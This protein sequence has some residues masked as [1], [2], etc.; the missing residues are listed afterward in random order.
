MTAFHYSPELNAIAR[1]VALYACRFPDGEHYDSPEKLREAE[2]KKLVAGDEAVSCLTEVS[3]GIY[4]W[5]RLYMNS[6]G[7]FIPQDDREL[8]K[9]RQVAWRA[10]RKELAA[11]EKEILA[12]LEAERHATEQVMRY[13]E[14][15]IGRTRRE[16]TDAEREYLEQR[17]DSA[18]DDL[19]Q[20][21]PE[22]SGELSSEDFEKLRGYYNLAAIVRELPDNLVS[23]WAH[24]DLGGLLKAIEKSRDSARRFDA[25]SFPA[26]DDWDGQVVL[27]ELWSEVVRNLKDYE[28][29]A[30]LIY[31]EESTRP[32][33]DGDKAIVSRVRRSDNT[34]SEKSFNVSLSAALDAIEVNARQYRDRQALFAF[35]DP[36]DN[37]DNNT[38]I[39]EILGA[40]VR[41]R[42]ERLEST[43]IYKQSIL[44]LD[45]PIVVEDYDWR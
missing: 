20:L 21:K 27:H 3:E 4:K 42:V 2:V 30:Q 45:S 29:E 13:F 40:T 8:A 15:C 31:Y 34:W 38:W 26:Y 35:A 11:R 17:V 23:D 32:Y 39:N 7:E 10:H 25:T 37:L 9:A 14:Y 5:K 41:A 36:D 33:G 18:V 12:E 43:A 16:W 19:R 24:R 28:E 44:G 6:R 22:Q 1:C